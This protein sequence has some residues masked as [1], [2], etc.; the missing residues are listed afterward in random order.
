MKIWFIIG[1]IMAVIA[2][3]VYI[4]A[5]RNE[6][7]ACAKWLD[8]IEFNEIGIGLV[9]FVFLFAGP[10]VIAIAAVIGFVWLMLWLCALFSDWLTELLRKK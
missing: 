2:L 5:V 3:V 9:L 7:S 10:I 1:A 8:K 6:K 4:I